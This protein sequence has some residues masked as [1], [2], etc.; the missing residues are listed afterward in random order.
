MDEEEQRGRTYFPVRGGFCVTKSTVKGGF[1][2]SCLIG[3]FD[4]HHGNLPPRLLLPSSAL[5]L[6]FSF[7]V[8]VL[9]PSSSIYL[10]THVCS[11]YL[12]D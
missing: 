7:P 11:C 4:G 1:I 12:I 8:K 5:C 3:A 10:Y 2:P 9:P 6:L